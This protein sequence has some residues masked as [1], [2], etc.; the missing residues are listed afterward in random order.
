MKLGHSGHWQLPPKDYN[1]LTL[2]D[3]LVTNKAKTKLAEDGDL[4]IIPERLGNPTRLSKAIFNFL[5]NKGYDTSSLSPETCLK[6]PKA[7]STTEYVS[8]EVLVEKMNATES[9]N[10]YGF[11]S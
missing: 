4:I 1:S 6:L 10:S 5:V 9:N 7:I 3:V 2:F 8:W 11:R